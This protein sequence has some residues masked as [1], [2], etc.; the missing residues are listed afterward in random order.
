MPGRVP[1]A[2]RRPSISGGDDQ[3]GRTRV[4]GATG[5]LAAGASRSRCRDLRPAALAGLRSVAGSATE[6]AQARPARPHFLYRGPAY[7]RHYRLA[8]ASMGTAVVD[9]SCPGSS[10]ALRA[11]T[12]I[13][14]GLWTRVN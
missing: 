12:P 7:A 2:L 1:R 6:E 8:V 13:F 3:R 10:A 4:A 9:S 14:D 11:F 5:A